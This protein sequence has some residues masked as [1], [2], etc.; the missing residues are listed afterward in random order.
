MRCIARYW[1]VLMLLFVAG[2]GYSRDRAF[3]G[4][5][6]NKAGAG[7]PMAA[8]E[9]K[10]MVYRFYADNRGFFSFKA[11]ADAIDSF[12][13]SARGYDNFRFPVEDLPEDSII[14]ELNKHQNILADA[15]VGTD[16]RL[17]TA[18]AGIGSGWHN[19]SCYL[20][21]YDEIAVYLPT[22]DSINGMLQ[23]VGCYVTRE[24]VIRNEFKMHIYLPDSAT[25]A[26]GEEVTDSILIM[27][28]R[29]GNEWVTADMSNRLIQVRGGLYVSVEWIVGDKNNYYSWEIPIG[30]SNYYAGEDSLRRVFNG[31][32]LGMAWQDAQPKVYRRYASNIY[33]HKD[34]GKWYL[35]RS[36]NGG[37][38]PKGWIAPM[39]YYTYTYVK[40]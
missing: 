24:G 17:R 5:I 35:T 36:L 25:G 38:R 4:R 12:I 23:E 39:I 40:K 28:A 9:S 11:D 15:T 7:L 13:F 6:I 2:T 27:H 3:Y 34:E 37:H 31:Q 8:I 22:K 29:H 21:I 26:P 20:N 18:T 19:T 16:S 32:V 14:I 33:R 10:N 30:A 1:V